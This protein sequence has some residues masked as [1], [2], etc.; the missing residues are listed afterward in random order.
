VTR[1]EAP[2]EVVELAEA[3]AAARRRRDWATADELRT[4]IEAAGWRVADAATLYSLER[5]VPPDDEGDGVPRYGSS[6]SVPSRLGEAPAGLASV[7]MWATDWPADVARALRAL[8]EDSAAGTQLIVVANAPSEAQAD[9]LATLEAVDGARRGIVT[10]VVW[11]SARL[12]YAAA[13]NAGIRRATAPVVVVLD[14][15]IEVRGDLVSALVS[16]LADPTVAVAGPFGLVSPDLRR[17]EEPP[18]GTVDVDAI[19]GYALA[20]RRAD[21]VERGPLDE[22]FVFYRNLDI[23]WSL[24]LRDQPEDAHE[25]APPRRAVRVTGVD[26]VRHEH[27]G[28]SALSED[29]RNRL[30]KRNF[31][32]VLKRFAS[33]RDL[34]TGAAGGG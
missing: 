13:L 18:E 29:E 32:R 19:E 3:R 9:A 34:L 22:H 11:T 12:G 21:Y 25:D 23:W 5:A 30:S 24:V 17:F 16:A 15:S 33:R 10:E 1:E 14:T 7:V 4:R 31:Y 28:W 6:A 2:P 26:V 27:R 8:G 20:F